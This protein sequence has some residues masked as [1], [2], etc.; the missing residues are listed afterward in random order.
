M[1]AFLLF[2]FLM[3]IAHA[4][5]LVVDSL[6]DSLAP[7]ASDS[8]IMYWSC[9]VALTGNL[10]LI[11]AVMCTG[12]VCHAEPCIH[13]LQLMDADVSAPTRADGA[14]PCGTRRQ[15]VV[16]SLDELIVSDHLQLP[17]Y[18]P[19]VISTAAS[20]PRSCETQPS[21]RES[22]EIR[23]S[24]EQ[25]ALRESVAA[26]KAKL[27]DMS[28]SH[29]QLYQ[30]LRLQTQVMLKSELTL[31]QN[32]LAND[33]SDC[34]DAHVSKYNGNHGT[35]MSGTGKKEAFKPDPAQSLANSN[36]TEEQAAKEYD[37]PMS[38]AG[39]TKELKHNEDVNL[40]LVQEPDTLEVSQQQKDLKANFVEP[41]T[42]NG[43]G[44]GLCTSPH[45][46][47]FGGCSA[48][49]GGSDAGDDPLCVVR[50][51]LATVWNM[52][53][54]DIPYNQPWYGEELLE[55]LQDVRSSCTADAPLSDELNWA[56]LVALSATSEPL[57][58]RVWCS[59][60]CTAWDTLHD[61][62]SAVELSTAHLGLHPESCACKAH[63]FAFDNF[64]PSFAGL[65]DELGCRPCL[66][67]LGPVLSLPIS[68]HEASH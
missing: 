24:S 3:F 64:S 15:K 8:I 44:S 49:C 4:N 17:S 29:A 43:P 14:R 10:F 38:E 41:T 34:I 11:R 60:E 12:E 53:L 50:S 56:T 6:I 22:C 66:S 39:A 59:L 36:H 48:S 47:P 37:E 58:D 1:V 9:S 46:A 28:A 33:I 19:G 2:D 45:A 63:E 68:E 35:L 18:I 62:S 67:S 40:K 26:L 7:P 20:C 5:F 65:H 61:P 51:L 16:L 30:E 27:D 25:A 23:S 21:T 42:V 55:A 13:R 31:V 32:K 54:D 52:P 57:P